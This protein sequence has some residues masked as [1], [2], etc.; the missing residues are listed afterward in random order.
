MFPADRFCE[1]WLGFGSL[2]VS[3]ILTSK[4]GTGSGHSWP[5]ETP[6]GLK[7]HAVSG[8]PKNTARTE[9]RLYVSAGDR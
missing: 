2:K 5:R 9:N 3:S 4:D 8:H 7:R 6:T 1:R